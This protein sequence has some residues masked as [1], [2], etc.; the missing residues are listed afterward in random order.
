M[1]IDDII[2]TLTEMLKN[3]ANG[4]CAIALAGSHAKGL[5]DSDSDIDFYMLID[6]PKN[7]LSRLFTLYKT[8]DS[9]SSISM[10]RGFD[11]APYGGVIDFIYKGIQIEVTVRTFSRMEQRVNECL[12][13]KFEIFPEIWTSNGY[14]TFVYLSEL[15]FIKPIWDPYSILANYKTK[16]AKYP[17]RLRKAIIGTFWR[18]A[19][20]W[21]GNFH[22]DS[23]IKRGD[24][25]F[26]APIVMHTVLD[27]AQIIFALNRVYYQGDKKL[28]QTLSALS[29]C[30]AQLLENLE[31]L[32]SA[33]SDSKILQKQCDILRS[34][35]D[36]LKLKIKEI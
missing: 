24:Y 13:G 11:E 21:L 26:T 17:N 32:L 31:F 12:K 10:S 23:A 4:R 27:M 28:L 7:F 25:L 22:Y 1:Q 9:I 30:P 34:V 29:Y 36:E 35:R 33:S 15:N 14:Y 3:M 8:A 16:L 5:A 6:K 20:T 2:T 19:N 18:R